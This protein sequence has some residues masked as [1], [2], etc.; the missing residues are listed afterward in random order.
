MAQEKLTYLRKCATLYS[1]SRLATFLLHRRSWTQLWLR[2]TSL[3]R[4]PCWC[5]S[6]TAAIPK[7]RLPRY[8][9]CPS[10]HHQTASP[11]AATRAREAF[12][13]PSSD[14]DVI[15]AALHHLRPQ[16][17]PTHTLTLLPPCSTVNLHLQLSQ[18]H[19]TKR[20]LACASHRQALL[21]L[22]QSLMQSHRLHPQP[23][24]HRR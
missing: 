10:T 14:T 16:S 17:S 1:T 6:S 22:H 15:F 12:L 2:F 20:G 13:K 7:A 11:P 4:N 9:L 3:W 24:A 19:Y 21:L 8:H 5:L 23:L 18:Q